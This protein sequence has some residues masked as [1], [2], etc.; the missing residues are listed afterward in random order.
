MGTVNG[1]TAYNVITAPQEQRVR[2]VLAYYSNYLGVEFVETADQGLTIGTGDVRAV[3]PTVNAN[4]VGGIEGGSE[5]VMNSA[6]DW[7]NSESG[8]AY[9]QTAMH[10]IGHFLGL[11]HTYELPALTIQGS[12][13]TGAGSAAAEPVFPGDADILLGQYLHPQYGNDIQIYKFGL[14]QAGTLNLETFAQQLNQLN[15]NPGTYV[16]PSELNTVITLY[17]SSGKIIARN[18]DY[19]GTD[20]FVSMQ[21]TSGT[22]YVAITSTGNTNF[23][24]SIVNSGAGGSTEGS[25]QLRLTFTPNN[26]NGIRDTNGTQIDGDGDGSPG[27]IYNFWFDVAASS[28]TIFVDK[29]TGVDAA[30]GGGTLLA[31]YKTISY[32]LAHASAGMIVRIEGNGGADGN[33]S[34]V[35]DNLSYNIGFDSLGNALSDGSTFQIPKGVT[36]MVDAGAIIKLRGANI[37]VGSLAQGI[38]HSGGALQVLGTPS[39]TK[40][41]AGDDIGTV[42]FTSYYNTSQH[43]GTDPGTNKGTLAAGNWGGIVFHD[44]SDHENQ[45]IFL[46][47]VNHASIS[48]GGGQVVVNSIPTPFDAIHLIDARPAISFNNIT[49]SANAAIS[50]D[51]NAFQES[52]FI[53]ANYEEDYERAGPSIHGNTVSKNTINGIF[54]RIRTDNTSGQ[55]LDPLTVSARLATTDMVYV[56]EENLEIAGNPGGNV[57]INQQTGAVTDPSDPNGRLTVRT[58]ASLKIDPGAIIKSGST[59]I[60]TQVGGGQL[61]AEGTAAK[62]IVFTS[63]FDDRYGG[64]GTMDTTNDGVTSGSQGEWGGIFFG[65]TSFGSLDHVLVT[66]AGGQTSIEG[67]FATFDAVEIHQAQVRIANST[68]EDNATTGD[69]SDRSGRTDATPAA[70]FIRGAQPVILNNT[71]RDNGTSADSTA[72]AISINV[73]ALNSQLVTDWGDSTGPINI[74][75][76]SLT[77]DGPFVRGNAIGNNPINGM[78]VRGG[79]ITTDVVWDDTD[80]VHVLE[81]LIT[82]SNQFS[83]TGT[84]RLESSPTESLVV[85]LLGSAAGFTASGTPLDI[86]D[87][88][89]GSVQI[90]GSPNHSVILTSLYDSTVGAGFMPNGQADT[91][92]ANLKGATSP[93][94]AAGDWSGIV[95]DTYSNDTNVDTILEQ[96]Q[97]FTTAGDTN[98]TPT[99]AQFLGTL[100]PNSKAGDDNSRLGF[101]VIGSISQTVTSPGGGDVDVYSFQGTAGTTAWLDIDQTGSAL[102]SV[103]ELINADG[104]VI[105]RSDNSNQEQLNPSLL[106][107][108]ND[109]SGNPIG[110]PMQ[111]GF[112]GSSGPYTNPDFFSSNPLDAGMRVDLPGTAGSI[113]TYYVRVRASNTSA[114]MSNL[115]AGLTK[116]E[117][118]LNIRLQ[119]LD[120]YP[121]S[122]VRDAD[123]RYATNASPD[124]RQTGTLAAGGRLLAEF[125][126]DPDIGPRRL[127]SDAGSTGPG[128][129][130]CQQQQRIERGRKSHAAPTRWCGSSST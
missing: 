82:T 7:G 95:L 56:L 52:E 10:E 48:Y 28:Q 9:F 84:I 94:P 64:G 47:Y 3:D 81:D 57:F 70:I 127:R 108:T 102:D 106:F 126:S 89:G 109:P 125:G 103:V 12:A 88:V 17:D 26:P 25:Y 49:S 67:G 29:Q 55:I 5:A 22:Y 11:G 46:D 80:I 116:G 90:I 44:D 45:G 99:K 40:N 42:Y 27:G 19:Y 62:P 79:T 6:V 53:G 128:Q 97:G 110:K 23:D 85:K 100:A 71:I 8:G 63:K 33:L 119:N 75:Y 35:T 15:S 66:F 60:E 69:T 43:I 39:T 93:A 30:T 121:G 73:N 74:Q 20:S 129:P 83:L 122:V 92:T 98:N 37:D 104:S 65:P 50:A 123:I 31:P 72:A 4:G 113:N 87:R 96:E 111:I 14:S 117:Y 68:I 76:T 101:T 18:D 24:P 21:L 114:G 86:N 61:I 32:A 130:A 58:G 2:E 36:V 38:D 16:A 91:D 107:T 34:T 41:T 54:I 105:A 120:Q 1:A 124:R 78:L 77:N 13:E 51:P 59:R 118:Q 115:T 112:T